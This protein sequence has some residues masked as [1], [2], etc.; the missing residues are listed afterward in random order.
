VQRYNSHICGAT[1]IDDKVLLSA[2]SCF[3]N[4][5][6]LD[7]ADD[8]DDFQFKD[9]KYSIKGLTIR[10]GSEAKSY[11]GQVCFLIYIP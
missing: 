10:A 3:Y 9:Y 11:G 6:D 5:E 1:I 4:E 2:A 8:L 7:T